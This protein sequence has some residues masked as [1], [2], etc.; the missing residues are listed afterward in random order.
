MPSNPCRW[1]PV[2]K[3]AEIVGPLKGEPTV[4]RS[5]EVPDPDTAGAGCLYDLVLQPRIGKGAVGVQVNLA[6]DV[7]EERAVDGAL[8]QFRDIAAAG[9]PAEGKSAPAAPA[10]PG[11]DR[12]GKHMYG[13]STFR[14]RLGH[15]TVSVVSLTPDVVPQRTAALATLVRDAIPD[16]PFA[17]QLDPWLQERVRARGGPLPQQPSGPD[18][19]VLLTRAEAEPVL[20]KLIVPPYRSS[21]D[22]PLADPSGEACAYFTAGHRVLLVRPHWESGK[23]I[24]GMAAGVGGVVA[25]IVGDDTVAASDTLEGPWER[26][27]ANG[28]TGQL[29]FLKGD[30]MLELGYLTSSTDRAGAVRLARAV[31]GRL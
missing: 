9:T 6:G 12:V 30:R 7:I 5:L 11:W 13:F 15:V 27:A 31:V 24:F 26:A 25:N 19:C 17:F 10:P 20:G 18:P 14:G 22:S 23:M 16:L 8:Q 2:A 4:V 21:G 3:V 29:Y 28:T 1:I